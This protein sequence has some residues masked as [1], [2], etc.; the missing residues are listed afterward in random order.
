MTMSFGTSEFSSESLFDADFATPS[1]H[2]G[3]TFVASSG[4]LGSP[5][6]YP[7]MSPDVLA[8]GG[9]T[10]TLNADNT[11]QG[12][13]GWSSSGGGQSIYE[14]EPAFQSGVQNTGMRTTPDVSFDADP[15]TGVQIYDSYMQTNPSFQVA[16]TSLAAPCWAGLIAIA[17]QGRVAAGGTT[18]DG[19]SQTLPALYSLPNADFHDIT[20]GSNGGYTAGPGYDMVTGIGSPVANL[21]VP[22]LA[23][24]QPSSTTVGSPSAPVTTQIVVSSQ[25]PAQV[26]AGT[27]FSV[28]VTVENASG[29]TVSSYSGPLMIALVTVPHDATLGGTLIV[30]ATNGVATFSNLTIDSA[31]S[32]Y[33]LAVAGGGMVPVTATPVT[34]VPAAACRLVNVYQPSGSIV[35]GAGFV[36]AAAVEDRYGNLETSY[37]AGV[38]LSL[39]NN[40]VGGV[41]SGPL[42]VATNQGVAIFTGLAIQ[43]AGAGYTIEYSSGSLTPALT[44]PLNVVPAAALHLVLA[45]APPATA[46]VG[47]PFQLTTVVEDE[48]GN[49]VS[50]YSGKLAVTLT[51]NKGK[52]RL[53]GTLTA[54][55]ANGVA[56]FASLA[57][58]T[59]GNGYALRVTGPGLAPT[60]TAPFNVAV[61]RK[62]AIKKSI[63]HIFTKLAPAKVKSAAVV[64]VTPAVLAHQRKKR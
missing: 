58:N 16:G 46:T 13:V 34:V 54:T 35:A 11:Y 20:S 37:N 56:T 12:E 29:G 18:L 3:V 30:N 57:V 32:G 36:L 62:I 19:P 15:M 22:A 40:P 61:A 48:F 55:V 50:N 1:G 7:G 31:G 2:Q 59:A 26:T 8:V 49:V 52:G 5:A 33:T 6:L 14:T 28:S 17:N 38:T 51:G 60:I 45:S 4:D 63:A 42:T 27:P 41:L 44:S 25:A 43:K 39:A 21:L 64:N 24:Y 23:G 53:T 9:T 47:S 10:L